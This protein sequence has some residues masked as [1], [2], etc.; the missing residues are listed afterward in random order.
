MSLCIIIQSKAIIFILLHLPLSTKQEIIA[1]EHEIK[2][3]EFENHALFDKTFLDEQIDE[4]KSFFV[5]SPDNSIVYLYHI[6][7]KY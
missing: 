6:F 4:M 5:F 2:N 1:H 3:H 7:N